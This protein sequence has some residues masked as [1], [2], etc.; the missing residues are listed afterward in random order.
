MY[1]G[2]GDSLVAEQDLHGHGSSVKYAM[3]EQ[4]PCLNRKWLQA[5]LRE[6]PEE[7]RVV[8]R[9]Y[10]SDSALLDDAL[11][12]LMQEGRSLA[13]ALSAMIVPAWETQPDRYDG[14]AGFYR[15]NA[16]LVE[17]W[18]GP[19]ALMFSDGRVA[20]AALDRNGLRPCRYCVSRSG[21]VVAAS[22]AGVVD[23]APEEIA[24]MGR[25]GPGEM[26]L[27]DLAT[28]RLLHDPEIK[29]EESGSPP[30]SHRSGPA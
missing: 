16:A 29:N 13:G 25:L 21:R 8:L 20:G 22:E 28:G 1:G 9:T 4:L 15:A 2:E 7:H 24:E 27:A 11:E 12:M 6:A 17:P 14:L 10:S 23:F 3:I 18:D 19:A 30:A 5:R 26:L